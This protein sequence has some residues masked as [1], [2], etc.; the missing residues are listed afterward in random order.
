MAKG[1]NL[2]IR[3]IKEVDKANKRAHQEANRNRLM[4]QREQAKHLKE[5]EKMQKNAQKLYIQEEKTHDKRIKQIAKEK[6]ERLKNQEKKVFDK[7][8][9]ERQHAKQKI[10][11]SIIR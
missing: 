8:C 1:F 10:I 7:R 3:L 11:N 6:L 2:A 5:S 4:Q 9:K